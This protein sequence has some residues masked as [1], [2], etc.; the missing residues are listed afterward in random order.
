MNCALILSELHTEMFVV[1]LQKGL[2]TNCILW[3]CH[4]LGIQGDT[5]IVVVIVRCVQYGQLSQ[6]DIGRLNA[7]FR[8]ARN[9]PTMTGYTISSPFIKFKHVR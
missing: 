9:S 6:S 5:T 1:Q 8:R 4:F 3:K 2:R 7:L